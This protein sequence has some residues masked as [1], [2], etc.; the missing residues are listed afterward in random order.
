M[1]HEKKNGN[2]PSP[3]QATLLERNHH[4]GRGTNQGN[5]SVIPRL[6]L[7][8]DHLYCRTLSCRQK[9]FTSKKVPD[10]RVKEQ[11]TASASASPLNRTAVTKIKLVA[12]GEETEPYLDLARRGRREEAAAFFPLRIAGSPHKHA[13]MVAAHSGS[14]SGIGSRK[15]TPL[16]HRLAPPIHEWA[17][18][19]CGP[20]GGRAIPVWRRRGPCNIFV[21]VK[22]L[23]TIDHLYCKTLSGRQKWTNLSPK[24]NSNKLSWT[25]QIA[26]CDET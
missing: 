22:L 13:C 4:D 2:L 5:V 20:F 12:R 10:K 26:G 15:E 18:P 16:W 3:A 11:V 1:E 25:K 17:R 8:I 6:L 14:N 21:T 24:Q 23:L 9:C 7:A 19:R